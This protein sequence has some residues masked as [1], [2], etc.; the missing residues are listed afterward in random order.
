MMA[1]KNKLQVAP[2][3]LQQR[4]ALHRVEKIYLHIWGVGVAKGTRGTQGVRSVRRRGV[5]SARMPYR[6]HLLQNACCPKRRVRAQP[7]RRTHLMD[8]TTIH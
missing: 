5:R 1:F 7:G 8:M 4:A 3:L 6:I 2:L